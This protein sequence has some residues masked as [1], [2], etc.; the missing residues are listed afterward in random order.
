MSVVRVLFSVSRGL[1]WHPE[2]GLV[3]ES[4]PATLDLV[5]LPVCLDWNHMVF[6]TISRFGL[7]WISRVWFSILGFCLVSRILFG[8]LGFCLVSLDLVL[9][10]WGWMGVVS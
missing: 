9:Y 2:F 10:L 1:V 5:R 6:L 8:I 3:P 7:V 4:G